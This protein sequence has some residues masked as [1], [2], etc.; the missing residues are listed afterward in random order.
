VINV[1]F[2]RNVSNA[3]QY[4]GGNIRYTEVPDMGHY[5]PLSS[6]YSEAVWKWMFSQKKN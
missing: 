6:L 4:L 1:K 3:I 2:S 5:C